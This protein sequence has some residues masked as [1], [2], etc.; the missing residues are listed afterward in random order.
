MGFGDSFAAR[1]LHL[2][3]CM[4]HCSL[5]RLDQHG[6][7]CLLEG[8]TKVLGSVFTTGKK[9][10]YLDIRNYDLKVSTFLAI[11][12]CQFS[13]H[14]NHFSDIQQSY[15]AKRSSAFFSMKE[16]IPEKET[17]IPL[18]TYGR[19]TNFLPF[20]AICSTE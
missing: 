10:K 2:R 17:S 14:S 19:D 15:L 4:C 9:Y 18:T 11:K 7:K 3:T 6:K 8:I 13:I 16:R 5:C 12:L 20:L 1:K